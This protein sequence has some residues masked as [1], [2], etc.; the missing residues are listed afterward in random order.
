M[1]TYICVVFTNEMFSWYTFFL[2][3]TQKLSNKSLLSL[4]KKKE[5][6]AWAIFSKICYAACAIN[7]AGKL[8]CLHTCM[9]KH[10]RAHLIDK[11]TWKPRPNSDQNYLKVDIINFWRIQHASWILGIILLFSSL[12]ANLVGDIILAINLVLP[13]W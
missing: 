3:Q 1:K 9:H 6:F 4:E 2:W 7:R 13:I 10:D 12:I 8:I 5:T 11:P